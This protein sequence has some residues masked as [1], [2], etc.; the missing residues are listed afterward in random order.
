LGFNSPK[1][2]LQSPP[3]V[4]MRKFVIPLAFCAIAQAQIRPVCLDDRIGLNP[5]SRKAL[6]SEFRQLMED[7]FGLALSDE[8]SPSTVAVVISAHPPSRYSRALGLAYRGKSGVLPELRIYTQPVL[9]LLGDQVSA[10]QLGR[11]LARV[12]AHEVGHYFLQQLHH[13]EEGV[14]RA[15]FESK[16]LKN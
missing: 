12:A 4:V 9:R 6:E 15:S 7:R 16:H 5:F 8:C 13:D 10:A 2:L 14:M 11:A 3:E 1:I